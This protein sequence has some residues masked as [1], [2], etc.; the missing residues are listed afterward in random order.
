MSIQHNQQ[1][2][3]YIKNDS[4]CNNAIFTSTSIFLLWLGEIPHMQQVSPQRWF[5]L[6][7]RNLCCEKCPTNPTESV[8]TSLVEIAFPQNLLLKVS[9]KP[10]RMGECEVKNFPWSKICW[11]QIYLTHTFFDPIFLGQKFLWT[12]IFQT[13]D[14]FLKFFQTKTFFRPQ[15]FFRPQKFVRTQKFFIQYSVVHVHCFWQ[16]H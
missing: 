7:L 8:P 2:K 15:H 1:V 4:D 13:Q 9:H 10:G 12:K 14:F 11:T 16:H 5:G 3:D 6:Y